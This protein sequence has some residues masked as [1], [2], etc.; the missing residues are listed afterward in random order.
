MLLGDP[1]CIG[2]SCSALLGVVEHCCV[3]L[4]VLC[5]ILV[6]SDNA[7]YF[8]EYRDCWDLL[9]GVRVC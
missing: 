1:G 4:G 9:V 5:S 8:S 2:H 6:L 3:L 7:G